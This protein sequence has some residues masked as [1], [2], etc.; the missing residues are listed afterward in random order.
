MEVIDT[1]LQSVAYSYQSFLT[2]HNNRGRDGIAVRLSGKW[3][4]NTL[5]AEIV[6]AWKQVIDRGNLSIP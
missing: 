4:N 3:L 6:G 2:F 1:H 5:Q